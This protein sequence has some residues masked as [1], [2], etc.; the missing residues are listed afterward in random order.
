M[1][2]AAEHYEDVFRPFKRYLKYAPELKLYQQQL[3]TQKTIFRN[4]CLKLLSRTTG[5]QTAK[6]MLKTSSH[7]LWQDSNLNEKITLRLGDSE[8]AC[9]TVVDLI[10][11]KL[12]AIEEETESFA[13]AIQ[14]SIPL[15]SV[16][17]KAWRSR[18]GKKLKFSFSEPRLEKSLQGLRK[19][20]QDFR[21]IAEQT[22]S[23][24][25]SHER[26]QPS[27]A[28]HQ[29]SSHLV[30]ECK[31]I[32][33]AS[34]RLCQALE[35]A[36]QVHD[37]HLAHFRLESHLVS[38]EDDGKSTVRFN[39]AFAHRTS[40]S[41]AAFDPVWIAVESTFE[42]PITEL[43]EDDISTNH[44]VTSLGKLSNTLKRELAQPS[45]M[46]T[47]RTKGKSVRF[48]TT[49]DNRGLPRE[50]NL[51]S[52]ILLDPALPDFSIHHGFCNQI[53]KCKP[54]IPTRKYIGWFEKSGPC[55]HLVYFAPPVTS[56]PTQKST[57]LAQIFHS[58]SQKSH[59]DQMLQH[60]RLRL[61]RQL[62][63]AVLQ[64]HAT[65]LLGSSWRSDDVVFFGSPE[66]SSILS[67][68]PHLNVQVGKS[69]KKTKPED[70]TS[71]SPMPR[72]DGEEYIRNPY[73]FNLGI[74][75]IELAHQAPLFNLYSSKSP[76]L[77]Q[78]NR[79]SEF[80]LANRISKSL[81]SSLGSSYGKIVRK[82]LGCDFGEGTTDLNDPA[83]QAVFHRDVVCELERL[84]RA[85]AM[86]QLGS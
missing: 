13:L 30:K 60:E 23:L 85:F 9:K 11:T 3:G 71:S 8:S 48:A 42:G 41:S 78:R 34:A 57:S 82:C 39:M 70:T 51:Y 56:C 36:C 55:K 44:S 26:E 66:S 5:H 14:Q 49:S 27:V 69:N 59:A 61:A 68:P 7:C 45:E 40:T 31:M 22:S 12:K 77:N 2:S 84:E 81:G 15:A 1:I 24:V 65:P 47:K 17:D 83:L 64:Y 16:G 63:S 10:Q 19:L 46:P 33:T 52:T 53:L 37:E 86:I 21:T 18:I 76:L 80:Q 20:N 43:K 35:R 32:Q 73:L 4:E 67:L 62:A 79:Y 72:P 25:A 38:A 54:Q 50:V 58:V 75:L 29:I 74:I 6:D 28:S